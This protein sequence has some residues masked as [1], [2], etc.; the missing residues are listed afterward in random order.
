MIEEY[1]SNNIKALMQKHGLTIDELAEELNVSVSTINR[2]LVGT[3]IDPR[4]ST[5]RPLSKFFDVT[6]EELIGDKPLNLKLK[7]NDNLFENKHALYQVPI[8]HW[9]QIKNAKDIVPTLNFHKWDNW[10]VVYKAMSNNAYALKIKQSSLPPPFY[11]KSIIVIDPEKEPKDCDYTLIISD[12][13]PILTQHILNG[14]KHL[15]KCLIFKE[16]FNDKEIKFCGTIVQ[17][18]HFY[19]EKETV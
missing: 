2:L 4:L 9:E 8:I 6:I 14:I 18:T 16:I 1:K 13:N 17:W 3:K 5:L 7:D 12:E 11:F 15:Y 19:C 10:T